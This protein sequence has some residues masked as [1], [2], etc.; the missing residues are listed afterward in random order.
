MC[1]SRSLGLLL[2]LLGLMA[3][4]SKSPT[5]EEVCEREVPTSPPYFE[6]GSVAAGTPRETTREAIVAHCVRRWT[7]LR[8]VSKER[9]KCETQCQAGDAGDDCYERCVSDF[10]V[11]GSDL[12][13]EEAR[14]K[15][16]GK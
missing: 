2:P 6:P 10:P 9:Y 5:P 13:K 12:A 15:A 1:S 4:C 7:A 11:S 8:T 3:A 16:T 14:L